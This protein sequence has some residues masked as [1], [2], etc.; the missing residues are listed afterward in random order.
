MIGESGGGEGGQGKPCEM[1]AQNRGG[2][3][4]GRWR[5]RGGATLVNLD[6]PYFGAS[7]V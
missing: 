5:G 2:K 4:R 3:N 6:A 7:S 1:K